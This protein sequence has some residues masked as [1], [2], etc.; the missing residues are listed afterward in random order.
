MID[1]VAD[2]IAPSSRNTTLQKGEVV[3]ATPE[4]VLAALY[5]MGIDNALI[6]IDGPEVPILDGSSKP[7]A[8]AFLSDGFEELHEVRKV[9]EVK[10]KIV[11]V[12]EESGAE[13]SIY[14]D[15]DFSVEVMIDF[16]SRVVG[17]QY[18]R[19]N[20]RSKFDTEFAHC[21]TFVFF[22]ELEP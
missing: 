15:N 8:E 11:L 17:H 16:N 20:S 10:E 7:Y 14:P 13:I 1:A 6:T 12:D 19:Y 4:H 18:A 22:H 5:A 9:F 3:V 21:R 2:Y